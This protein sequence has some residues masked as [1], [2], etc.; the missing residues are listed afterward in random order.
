MP[1]MPNIHPHELAP[2]PAREADGHGPSLVPARSHK[3]RFRASLA[4]ALE[5]YK[6]TLSKLAK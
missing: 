4:W 2:A 5:E 1:S 3:A 6:S